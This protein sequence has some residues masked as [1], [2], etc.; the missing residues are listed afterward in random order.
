MKNFRN[1][2]FVLK[3]FKTSSILN[4]S[5]LSVAFATFIIIMMQVDYD[6]NFD[7]H[8]ENSDRIYRIDFV[9]NDA[10][11]AVLSRS[12]ADIL[13][14]NSSHILAG[15]FSRPF[16]ANHMITVE[17]NGTA[18]IYRE[19]PML[20]SSSFTKVFKFKMLE[21]LDTALEEP[22]TVLLPRSI[23][24]KFFG[25]EP[26]VGKQI[27]L[28]KAVTV[29]GVYEDFPI[30][31]SIGNV[32]YTALD[33]GNENMNYNV[34]VLL[35]AP[36]AE[37]E[38]LEHYKD[39]FPEAVRESQL[40]TSSIQFTKLT[41]LHFTTDVQYDSTPKSNR[42]TVL[43]LWA[44]AFAI[45]LIAG[46]N[47]INFSLALVPRRIRSINTQ[48]V[49]GASTGAQ[50][51]TLISEAVFLNLFA[52]LL[53]L[54]LVHLASQTPIAGLTDAGIDLLSHP[55]LIAI[56]ALVSCVAGIVA[57]VYP[58]FYSTSFQPAMVLKGSFALSA[59][60]QKLRNLLISVQFVASL[61][62]II[63]AIFIYLQNGH[64]SKM[65]VGYDRDQ[66]I[67]TDMN[68]ALREH[69]DVFK[70]ELKKFS[71]IEDV[72]YAQRLLGTSAQ[73]MSWG[74]T[75]ND[76]ELRFQV[77]P[78]DPSFL[79]VMN[80]KVTEG[81]DFREDDKEGTEGKYI[82]NEKAQKE[83]ELAVNHHFVEGMKGEIIGFTSDILFATLYQTPTAMAFFV[84]DK[85]MSTWYQGQFA[86]I[87]VQAGSDMYAAM[88][89]VKASLSEIDANYPFDVRFYD[90]VMNKVYQ[91]EHQLSFLIL[92]FSLIAIIISIA[93]VFGLVTFETQYRRREISIRKVFGSSIGEVM[94]LFGKTYLIILGICF[95]IACPIAYV[96]VTR[97][98]EKFAY[99]IPIY[100]WVFLLGGI[101]V[102][103]VTVV[104]VMAQSYKAATT[105][106]TK[107]LT[108]N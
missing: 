80:I 97:W 101:I 66:V 98:L 55:A 2:L 18:V 88:Q 49:L 19:N 96:V 102:L 6:R 99:K 3:R 56:T 31:S 32:I 72:A 51:L 87:R 42:S 85:E 54:V 23:A 33:D 62:L 35:D 77:L 59:G 30:N 63:S 27:T 107:A 69:Y 83:F 57:G 10:K 38:I 40:K 34:F 44:I 15:A 64:L 47:F 4:I 22:N 60:G 71:G 67:V 58:A 50:R 92:L 93:G 68:D 84:A 20:V 76:K 36:G 11:W 91:K 5:G 28:D 25:N 24:Q 103:L 16:G 108:L 94:R 46:I 73:Y 105:N 26:A 70:T 17:Q 52:W 48:K 29:G 100:W 7:K 21:G 75:E 45:L 65:P 90:D 89:H 61:V 74:F 79:K 12:F 104:T 1:F 13:F 43:V 86:Y 106:P 37:Q 39:W 95:V 53:S 81:R 9:K 8:H 41:D 82:F 78:V 14:Q